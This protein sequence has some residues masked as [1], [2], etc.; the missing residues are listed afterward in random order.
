MGIRHWAPAARARG[1]GGAHGALVL[2]LGAL[3]VGCSGGAPG[4]L[5][6]PAPWRR[7][8]AEEQT[9]R[10]Q[11]QPQA[12]Q[13][14]RRPR[15]SQLQAGAVATQPLSSRYFSSVALAGAI[16]CSITHTAVVP[17][18]VI[19]TALQTDESLSGPR[20]AI[21]QLTRGCKGPLCVTPFF[22]GVGAT[23]LGYLMQGAT[24][25][26]GYELCKRQVLNRL[27]EAGDAGESI[28][29]RFQ[30][31]IMIASAACAETVASAA[32]C[33]L[34][35]IK[36]RMQTCP[37]LASLGLRRAMI[38]V[39]KA[40]GLGA[41]F[42]GFAPIALRQVPYTACKLVS[43]E[44]GIAALTQLVAANRERLQRMGIRTRDA[45][46]T[47]IVLTAGLMA[48]AS[49]AFVSQ[50]FDLLLTRLCGS[51]SVTSL[52]SCL[53]ADGLREQ[54]AYLFSLGP[55]A[56]TGL[57]PRLMMISIMTSCQFFLYDSMR[58]AL[59]CPPVPMLPPAEKS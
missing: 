14:S 55:A 44:L 1:R 41:L 56:F 49:A 8:R 54:L 40:D 35:V 30:L 36:L 10:S 7:E 31:P 25:F 20:A 26:G 4:F 13:L 9:E 27:R 3:V 53:I 5:A 39:V 38:D 47:A 37:R 28:A 48:G 11:R 19:K 33:P 6:R 2:M 46:H 59:N 51:S 29:R 58:T 23:A 16:S 43:F 52:S 22:N 15:R 50:P 21:A 18:D 12:Q 34:E 57:G 17:L 42:R 32:L 24:K 45:S